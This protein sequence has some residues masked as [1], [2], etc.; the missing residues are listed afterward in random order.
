MLK[1]GAIS[2]LHISSKSKLFPLQRKALANAAK[3]FEHDGVSY[4]LLAGDLAGKDAPHRLTQEER[5]L[6]YA[7]VSSL[8]KFTN[9]IM[10]RGNHDSIFEIPCFQFLS[11]DKFKCYTFDRGFHTLSLPEVNFVLAPYT[12]I[13]EYGVDLR[14]H[15][16]EQANVLI[17]EKLRQVCEKAYDPSKPNILL[18]HQPVVGASI[19]GFILHSVR[20]FWLD[21][22]E[23][24]TFKI[25]HVLMGHIHES[26]PI[27]TKGH[28]IG[29]P[30]PTDFSEKGPKGIKV[31][32]IET[33]IDGT[34][35]NT[36][37]YGLASWEMG[38]ITCHWKDGE[39]TSIKRNYVNTEDV[40]A[41]VK[42]ILHK[43]KD[44]PIST[45]PL[46]EVIN[47]LL[48]KGGILHPHIDRRALEVETDIENVIEEKS[49]ISLDI[50][51][52]IT[53]EIGLLPE[54]ERE[55]IM[56]LYERYKPNE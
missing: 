27:G 45:V 2:D 4:V 37:F 24:D 20:D 46:L 43:E 38:N 7:W 19:A 10:I 35:V 34:T 11:N 41:Y 28:Y 52:M 32:T 50:Y 9:V 16:K 18:G 6:L 25:D 44:L 42:V 47:P 48:I 36:M 22:A 26:Q 3:I 13:N 54:V 49:D 12:P 33:G 15:T 5:F 17:A 56:E 51:G 53:Q 30:Y 29:S 39:W 8:L 21:P 31:D 1:I 40:P 55:K 23:L 14:L